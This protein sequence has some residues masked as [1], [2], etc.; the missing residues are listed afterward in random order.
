MQY[1]SLEAYLDKAV[2]AKQLD[3]TSASVILALATAACRIDQLVRRDGLA[4][5]LGGDAGGQNSDGDDQKAL[6][7][8]A[9]EV[10]T[11][12]I[13]GSG[14]GQFL[15]EEQDEAVEM[16]AGGSVILA[17]DPLDGSSNISVNVTIGTIFSILPAGPALQPGSAQLAAGFFTYG[18]QTGLVLGAPGLGRISSFT[19]DPDSG[20]FCCRHDRLEI[21]PETKEF[22]INS[23]YGGHWFAPVRKWM[24]DVLAGKTGPTGRDW[25]M[26]WVGSLV[27]DAWRVLHRGGVFLYPA[28][29]RSG[30]ENGRLRLVYEA[31]PMAL[32]VQLAGGLATD[33]HD[34]ILERQP[35]SLHQRTALI[36]GAA[37]D[38]GVIRSM[39]QE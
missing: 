3:S 29:R 8:L 34:T 37:K 28:D 7:V 15:S 20:I 13:R 9:E 32:L 19:L 36:F 17:V 35:E 1:Q 11:A 23:A 26:R 24:D 10:I 6:D 2:S 12:S 25:R 4:G 5:E 21:P 22:A 27:A 18:P 14:V 31:N 30:Q 33:G 38:V 39:H 16:D